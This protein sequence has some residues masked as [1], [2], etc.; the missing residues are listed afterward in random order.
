MTKTG[1]FC[2]WPSRLVSNSPTRSAITAFRLLR[3]SLVS[4]IVIPGSPTMST[5]TLRFSIRSWTMKRIASKLF[6]KSRTNAWYRLSGISPIPSRRILK[7]DHLPSWFSVIAKTPSSNAASRDA[8]QVTVVKGHSCFDSRQELTNCQVL[9]GVE[10]FS[11]S[12]KL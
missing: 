10:I 2:F 6:I 5:S 3:T 12:Q 9:L 7:A 1:M 4:T 11:G 8:S